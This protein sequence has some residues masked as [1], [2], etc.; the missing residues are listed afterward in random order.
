MVKFFQIILL[1][2]LAW[3]AFRALRRLLRRRSP[4]SPP[5][6]PRQ[7]AGTTMVPCAHCGLHVPEP[8]AI[9]RGDNYYCSRRHAAERAA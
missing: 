4:S 2:A 8:E 9:R 6:P 1:F 5:A 3:F 7:V